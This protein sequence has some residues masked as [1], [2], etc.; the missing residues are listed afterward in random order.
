M[1]SGPIEQR[2][3]AMVGEVREKMVSGAALL[4]AK[5][6][7]EGTSFSTVL[8]LTGAPRG[9]IY[10]H[11]P[12]G[13]DELVGAAL[14]TA[15]ARTMAALDSM[16]G[17]PAD[18][19]ARRFFGLWRMVLDRSM[20]T[21]GCA[22]LAVTVA[23]DSPQLLDLT[24]TYFR[25]WRS[26]LTELLEAGGLPSGQAPAFAV[27]MIAASEGAVVMSRAQQSMEP[28]DLVADQLLHQIS[29]KL[30]GRTP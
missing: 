11:F 13:K 2:Q 23:T 7:L 5:R 27:L 25:G 17:A 21:A 12:D 4:L 6:G 22:L 16:A 10:H 26:R 15:N 9:S 3:A 30:A 8:E 19:V 29:G 18:E 14:D 1:E 24:G 20:F 28:F